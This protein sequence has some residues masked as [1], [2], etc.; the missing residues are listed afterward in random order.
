MFR[1][2]AQTSGLLRAVK[3][4]TIRFRYYGDYYRALERLAGRSFDFAALDLR[5]Y[6]GVVLPLESDSCDAVVSNAVLE[7]VADVAAFAGE[8]RRVLRP[9]GW[10]DCVWHNFYCPS[11]SHLGPR[12]EAEDPWGHI[13]G[14][15]TTKGLNRLKPEEMRAAFAQELRVESLVAVDKSYR[16]PEDADYAAEGLDALTGALR[17]QLAEYPV[18]LLT[19]R[20]Y[21]IQ[22]TKV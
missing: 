10:V 5:T 1:E 15:R 12:V 21:L 18:D 22:A 3:A 13:V 6:D 19:T 7:H 8:I 14:G 9:G 20:G 17:K 11:G 16:T 4:G 2:T